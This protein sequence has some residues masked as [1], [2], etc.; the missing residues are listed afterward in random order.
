M[1]LMVCL[2][3][4]LFIVRGCWCRDCWLI[5]CQ[6][7]FMFLLV[8]IFVNVCWCL[9]RAEVFLGSFLLRFC[10]DF[11]FGVLVLC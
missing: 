6:H 1:G 11:F 9:L 2:R 7:L 5:V 4:L 8:F 10:C 3:I